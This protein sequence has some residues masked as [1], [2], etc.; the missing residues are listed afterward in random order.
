MLK[1]NRAELNYQE[2]VRK[3][4][5]LQPGVGQKLKIALLADVSTQHLVPILRALFASNGVDAH[6]YEAGFDTVQLEAF[7]PASGLYAFEPQ[8]VVILQSVTKLRGLYYESGDRAGFSRSKADGIESVWQAIQSR[9]SVPI[10]QSTFVIPYERA[11]GHFGAKVAGT[12]P[13]AISEINR[14]LCERAQRHASVFIC[15]IDYLAAWAGRRNFFDERLWALAKSLCSLELLPEVAQSIVDIAMAS[16]GRGIKCVVLDLDNTLWGGVIGDDGL[17]G[18]GLGDLDEGGAFRFF[19]LFLRSLWERGILLAVCSKNT[20][21]TA[22]RVFQEHPSMILREEHIAMFV[23]NWEDKASNIRRIREKLNIGFD[24]MVFLDDNPFERNLVRQLVPEILV[25]DLPEDPGLYVR[26]ICELNLF[27]SAGTSALDSQRTALY[28]TAEKRESE[29]Q[30]FADLAS[31]LKSLATVAELRRFDAASL[32]RIAQLI[33]RSNQFNLTTRRY[34]QSQCEA[35]MNDASTYPFSITVR[36][37]FGDFGLIA[38]IILKHSAD[39]LEVDTFLMSCR[40]LQRGVEQY[41]MNHIVEYARANHFKSIIGRY[42]PTAKNSMVQEFFG[43]F[44]FE[45][46]AHGGTEDGAS[47]TQWRLEVSRY[48]P[49]EVFINQPEEIAQ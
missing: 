11:H 4:R 36:D 7:N 6:I 8:L 20:E 45:R 33:Q 42:I 17:D 28:Q 19:Q 2:L 43:Q 49:R 41:A 15:D 16:L 12:L 37:R 32:G 10:I 14:D 46:D 13:G 35:L 38:V 34:S 22:R 30:H 48:V 18:I 39:T 21:S 47:G 5:R 9:L 24:S 25:P 23:A 26:A 1:Q 3:A 44:G 27:E 29:K 31:Y 40:V